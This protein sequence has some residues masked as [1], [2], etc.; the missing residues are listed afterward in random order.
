MR[1]TI[2]W[3]GRSR[4]RERPIFTKTTAASALG[5]HRPAQDLDDADLTLTQTGLTLDDVEDIVLVI[6]YTVALRGPLVE[7]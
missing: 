2:L 7:R 1:A 5:Q 4:R 3:S 6:T